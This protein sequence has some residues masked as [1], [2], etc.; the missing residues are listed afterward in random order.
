[1]LIPLSFFH[2]YLYIDDKELLIKSLQK[3][4]IQI[5]NV[6]EVGNS[7][8]KIKIAKVV[9][10]DKHPNAD[11]IH[12][13]K[14]SLGNDFLQVL[15]ADPY[16]E[17]GDVVLV[18]LH[19]CELPNGI[20]IQTR[21][22]RGIDSYGM[23]LSLS[24]LGWENLKSHGQGVSKFNFDRKFSA[25][26]G[27]DLNEVIKTKD[28]VIEIQPVPNRVETLGVYHLCK[29]IGFILGINVDKT[30]KNQN[31]EFQD[32]INYRIHID[33]PYCK[34]YKAVFLDSLKVDY[35][36][37]EFQLLLSWMGTKPVNNIVDLTN[38]LMYDISQPLHA[39]D[40]DSI[41][42][43]IVVRQGRQGEILEA[44][45][46]KDYSINETDIVISDKSNKILA[47]AGIIGSRNYSVKETSSK[48]IIEIANFNPSTVRKTSKKLNLYTNS[49]RRFERNIPTIYVDWC[50]TKLL[51]YIKFF[52]I[53]CKIMGYSVAGE[54]DPPKSVIVNKEKLQKFIGIDLDNNE[55][56]NVTKIFAEQYEWKNQNTIEIKTYRNDINAWWDIAEEICRFK[57]FDNL[58]RF[59]T[60]NPEKIYPYSNNT[61][62][63][64]QKSIYKIDQ[65]RKKFVFNG[66]FEVIGYNLLNPKY[67]EIFGKD[68]IKID[69]YMSIEN[70]AYRNSVLASVLQIAS[71]NYAAGYKHL[72][73]FEIGKAYNGKELNQLAFVVY[74]DTK[75]Y[76]FDHE[77]LII[78]ETEKI[79]NILNHPEL[80][81]TE[82]FIFL[83]PG[84]LIFS[85]NKCIG[86]LG[87]LNSYLL[88]Y[89]YYPPYTLVGQIDLDM[90][91][92]EKIDSKFENICELPPIYKDISFYTSSELNYNKFIK[93]LESEFDNKLTLN[94]CYLIDIYKL[95]NNNTS[96]TFRLEL[97]PRMEITN[98]DIN[99]M[100]ERIFSKLSEYGLKRRGM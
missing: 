89:I 3:I 80:I 97:K 4:G 61:Y 28:W 83:K 42:E 7:L 33:S 50:H 55:I 32:R 18:A 25:N 47:L 17:V 43:F 88:D 98:Q 79:K 84:Y 46:N 40:G 59:I 20:K 22:I 24:E 21:K 27:K 77:N 66:Y 90:I 65:I 26:I 35:S 31:V 74:N 60:Q 100:I 41:D 68:F 9:Q 10:K 51:E 96:Y 34:Y 78:Y 93:I 19:G 86:F 92:D 44:L 23:M 45:D 54:L 14:V 15:T 73:I 13:C 76:I 95:D 16:V 1:M 37:I 2:R 56:E 67:L 48:V 58:I 49:S 63:F 85:N 69:N 99:M 8:N 62:F 36:P 91:I 11:K 30:I 75:S 29:E 71:N 53:E 57:G 39:F 87:I 70:S 82:K 72:K 5:E 38:F 6:Y 64:M 81:K 52:N 94:K 12:I